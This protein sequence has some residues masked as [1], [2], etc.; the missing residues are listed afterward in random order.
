MDKDLAALDNNNSPNKLNT[1]N[2]ASDNFVVYNSN[3]NGDNSK[4]ATTSSNNGNEI[5][6]LNNS[7]KDNLIMLD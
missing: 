4:E 6:Q 3:S 1:E 5:E 7:L 2:S